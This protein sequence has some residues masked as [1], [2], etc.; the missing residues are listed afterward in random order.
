M[1]GDKRGIQSERLM[2]FN[3]IEYEMFTYVVSFILLQFM[4]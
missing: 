3:I 1:L 2:D 4:F